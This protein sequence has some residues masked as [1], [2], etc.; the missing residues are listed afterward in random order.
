MSF[1]NPAAPYYWLES[2]SAVE[3]PSGKHHIKVT[4]TIVDNIA[5]FRMFIDG[6]EVVFDKLNNQWAT[7][8]SKYT[9]AYILWIAGEYASG[10][11][12]NLQIR[13]GL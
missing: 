1:E 7:M 3:N 11:I 5:T 6:T 9:G 10:Q 2:T 12:S 8:T 4:R 13:S